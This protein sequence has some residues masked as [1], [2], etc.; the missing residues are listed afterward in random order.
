MVTST[1]KVYSIPRLA[2]PRAL[3]PAAVHCWPVTSQE[4]LQHRSGSVSVGSL[5][6]AAHKVCL[7]SLRVSGGHRMEKFY[8]VSKNKTRS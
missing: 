8:T 2:E 3:A 4:R 1:M 7:S 5:G 6:P